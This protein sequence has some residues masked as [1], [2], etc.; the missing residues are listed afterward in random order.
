MQQGP[1][2]VHS[3]I[4]GLVPVHGRPVPVRILESR[5]LE[6][7]QGHR[8]RLAIDKITEQVFIALGHARKDH[9]PGTRVDRPSIEL[10]HQLYLPRRQAVGCLGAFALQLFRLK[11]A[12]LRVVDKPLLEANGRGAGLERRLADHL[13]LG[14]GHVHIA[15][16]TEQ[17]A[18]PELGGI[19][20]D[21]RV[22]R[23]TGDDTIVVIGKAPGFDQTFKAAQRTAYPVRPAGRFSVVGLDQFLGMYR[24][25]V[26]GAPGIIDQFFRVAQGELP[27]LAFF[28]TAVVSGIGRCRGVALLKPGE[29]GRVHHR[30]APA[31]TADTQ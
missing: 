13:E 3:L 4:H 20:L 14:L 1:E 16:A 7:V 11:I 10:L 9:F 29:H 15:V 28:S 12:M 23:R 2:P 26:V 6:Q 24:H 30:S 5:V 17:P 25:Q 22:G 21:Q 19:E 27:A 31:K 8:E 18:G